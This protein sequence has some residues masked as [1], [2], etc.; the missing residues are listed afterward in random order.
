MFSGKH[1]L[2]EIKKIN[3]KKYALH[4]NDR[5]DLPEDPTETVKEVSNDLDHILRVHK[6]IVSDRNHNYPLPNLPWNYLEEAIKLR[7][8]PIR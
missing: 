8:N 2:E 3:W 5:I 4:L 7:Q 6:A 1:S